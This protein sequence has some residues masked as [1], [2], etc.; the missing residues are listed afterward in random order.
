MM[1]TLNMTACLNF[2]EV[3]DARFDRTA[4]PGHRL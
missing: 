1:G 4:Y 3:H 2:R